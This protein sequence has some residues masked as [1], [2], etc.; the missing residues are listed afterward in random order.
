MYFLVAKQTCE[1]AVK[2]SEVWMRILFNEIISISNDLL[3]D[4]AYGLSRR[5][6]N[7]VLFLDSC[8]QF[9]KS[10]Y[11]DEYKLLN[12]DAFI[13]IYQKFKPNVHY[14]ANTLKIVN[15]LYFDYCSRNTA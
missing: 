3:I 13:F 7:R 1:L 6:E 9:V 15:K 4:G 14:C 12:A 10:F 8:I 2:L 11:F 5:K